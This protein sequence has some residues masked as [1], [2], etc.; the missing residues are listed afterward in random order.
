MSILSFI[1]NLIPSFGRKDVKG[2]I[3]IIAKK[4]MD[5]VLPSLKL[6]EQDLNPAAFKTTYARDFHKDLASVLPP[7]LRNA[8][9][10]AYFKLTAIA[11]E[12]ARKL[13]DLLDQYVDKNVNDQ[14][15]VEGITYQ[16]A[17][18]LRLID[19]LDFFAEYSSRHLSFLV[20]SETNIEAFG[21]GDGNPFTPNDLKYLTSNRGSYLRLLNLLNGDPKKVLGDIEKIPEILVAETDMS[22]V[23]A[24]AGAASDP[25]QLNAIPI[26]SGLFYYQGIRSTD[27]D[28]EKFEC[29]KSDARLIELRLEALRNRRSRG[30][31][32]AQEE[33]IIHGYEGELTLARQRI[34]TMEE[35]LR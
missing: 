23:P 29:M 14:I 26:I 35:K 10:V 1:A 12:H 30:A 13:L 20:A 16:K 32:D 28:I 22:A 5:H 8:P 25:L 34:K 3:K 6:V 27:W 21:L 19:L 11:V 17:S 7:G 18:I 4:L 33:T 2:K 31:P 24:L 15:H 9:G